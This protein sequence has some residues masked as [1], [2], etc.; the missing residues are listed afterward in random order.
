[1][2]A[3]KARMEKLRIDSENATAQIEEYKSKAKALEADNL[4]KEQEIA[5]LSTKNT[6]LEEDVEKLETALAAAKKDALEGAQHGTTSENLQRK[7]QVL[8]E[9][10]ETQE[11]QLR[12]VTEKL[13]QTDVK[14]EHY[15]RK[16]SSLEA[17]LEEL[18]KKFEEKEVELK[19]A[20]TEIEEMVKLLDTI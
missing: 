10:L 8:E 13:R 9:E 17:Q 15:E 12:E 3:L 20:K 14:A 7:V 2:D 1:M 18:E 6:R 16:V 11:K 4:A 19:K 5:S